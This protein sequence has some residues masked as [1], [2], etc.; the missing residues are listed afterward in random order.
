MAA[1]VLATAAVAGLDQPD[2]VDSHHTGL[3]DTLVLRSAPAESF[4]EVVGSSGDVWA[5]DDARGLVLRL[6]GRS[7]RVR[8]RIGVRGRVALAAD[9]QG[10]WALRWGGR[11]WRRPNGPLLRIDPATNRI[12]ARIPLRAASGEPIVAFGV[13]AGDSGVWVWGPSR[14]LRLDRRTASFVQDFKVEQRH[15]ELTGAIL[16]E[17]GLLAVAADGHLLRVDARIG[18][19]TA[20]RQPAL[21]AAELLELTGR[22]LV[23]TADRMLLAVDASTGRLLWRR[24]LGFH[25]ET[26]ID[27]DGVLLAQGSALGDIGDR[28]WAIDGTTGRVCASTVLP[29]FGT[30]G[31][32]S[33]R[34]ALWITTADGQV[35][36]IPRL[37]ARLF[38]GRAGGEAVTPPGDAGPA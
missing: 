27:Y 38:V 2:G 10:V 34:G 35:I 19:R 30:V 18:V 5:D 13:L 26:V 12:A 20:G 31:M 15:G 36:A 29:S 28:L 6:D 37:L 21:T 17:G 25:V 14:V 22:R 24:R 9:G 7:G 1:L 3:L 11:F 32:T 16:T 23:A 33:V 8:A 4:G